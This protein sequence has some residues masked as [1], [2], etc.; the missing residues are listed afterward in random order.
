M[1]SPYIAEQIAPFS[2]ATQIN[3]WWASGNILG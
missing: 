3:Q 1:N 2:Q